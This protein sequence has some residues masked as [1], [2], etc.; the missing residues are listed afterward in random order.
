[1][2]RIWVIILAMG[3][4]LAGAFGCDKGEDGPESESP[5]WAPEGAAGPEATPQSNTMAVTSKQRRMIDALIQH[6][7]AQEREWEPGEYSEDPPMALPA[8]IARTPAE[9]PC[10][11]AVQV[12]DDAWAVWAP[13]NF[14][15]EEPTWFSYQYDAVGTGLNSRFTITAFADFDCDGTIAT[16]TTTGGAFA[17]D[18]Y[19]AAPIYFD[20]TVTENDGE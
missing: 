2:G 17:G 9:I 6:C 3:V 13:L 10:G 16:V 4:A 20:P 14:R 19:D 1:M 18:S 15:L 11:E 7:E 5:A 8:S 12:P